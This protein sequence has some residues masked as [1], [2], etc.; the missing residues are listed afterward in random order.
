MKLEQDLM[1]LERKFWTGNAEF[2]RQ[3]LDEKCL[4]AFKDRAG[5]Q[6]KEAIAGMVKE[7]ETWRNLKMDEKGFVVLDP[8]AVILTY[9]ADGDRKNGEHYQAVVS[10]GYVRRDGGWKLAFHQQ[11]PLVDERKH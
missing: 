1:E 11:T 8:N 9:E 3:H 10:S 2:F 5:V 4:T 7:G 6:N